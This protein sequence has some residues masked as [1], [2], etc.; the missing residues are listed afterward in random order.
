[1]ADYCN[2]QNNTRLFQRL[3]SCTLLGKIPAWRPC[4]VPNLVTNPLVK[5]YVVED[6]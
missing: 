4:Y 2:A 6:S 1:M 3:L 5:E